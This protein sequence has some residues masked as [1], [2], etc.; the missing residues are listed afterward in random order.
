MDL[1]IKKIINPIHQIAVFNGRVRILSDNFSKLVPQGVPLSGLDVGCGSGD[2]ATKIQ[3]LVPYVKFSGLD[4]LVRKET[5]IKVTEFDGYTLP[6]DDNSFDFTMISDVLH[7][8]NDPARI[9]QECVRVSRKFILIKDHICETWW[10][11]KI[12]KFM[13]WIGNRSYGVSLPYNYLSKREWEHLF[14]L[15][16]E[17]REVEFR[18]IKLYPIPFSYIFDNSLHFMAKLSLRK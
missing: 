17:V 14:A 6:F 3:K 16:N 12:L 13:D 1:F 5:A 10:D 18:N 8:T 15:S 9:L 11:D 4:V 7:H 2:L